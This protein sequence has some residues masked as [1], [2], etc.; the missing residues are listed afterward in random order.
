[1]EYRNGQGMKNHDSQLPN[2]LYKY[3]IA[4]RMDILLN[5][6]IRFTNPSD[7][8][9]PL[10]VRPYVK[11]IN[12]ERYLHN[13]ASRFT[14]KLGRE[15]LA[16]RF[17]QDDLRNE[18]SAMS[19]QERTRLTRR[20]R[21]ERF[22]ELKKLRLRSPDF[23]ELYLDVTRAAVLTFDRVNE[24][25]AEELPESFNQTVGVLSLTEE[26]DNEMMWALYADQNTGF[27][28]EF[29]SRNPFFNYPRLPGDSALK[30]VRYQVL[31]QVPHLLDEDTISDTYLERLFYTK[32]VKWE[33]EQEWR[34]LHE[35]EN[36]DETKFLPKSKV[37]LYRFPSSLITGVIF[38]A[39]M[40]EGDKAIVL[41]ILREDRYSHV[42]VHQAQ[43]GH[44]KVEIAPYR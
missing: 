1:M 6:K 36:A 8:N 14:S 5:G 42:N 30:K 22:R 26:A 21:R 20:D 41:E 25:L 43:I 4:E 3:V 10:D 12:S 29:D 37:C 7:L 40:S 39:F 27:V 16:E 28:L 19:P 35:L 31:E 23:R 11:Q 38:G 18:I 13:Q 15:R 2:R 32:S 17:S 34:M 33:H 9:D 24:E 44:V